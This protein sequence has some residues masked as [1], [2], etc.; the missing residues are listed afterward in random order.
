MPTSSTCRR[1]RHRAAETVPFEPIRAGWVLATLQTLSLTARSPRNS[2]GT[3]DC[4]EVAVGL[5]LHRAAR[6]LEAGG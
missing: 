6:V 1:R 4:D 5:A 2:T 3:R